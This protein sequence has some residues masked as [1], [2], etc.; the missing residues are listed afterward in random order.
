MDALLRGCIITI[1]QLEQTTDA[2]VYLYVH[3]IVH[4]DIK[5]VSL[6]ILRD[7]LLSINNICSGKYSGQ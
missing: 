7:Q 4:A 6:V 3:N 1:I 5:G 2:L